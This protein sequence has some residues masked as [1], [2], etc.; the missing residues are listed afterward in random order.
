MEALDCR[1]RTPAETGR[2]IIERYNASMIGARLEARIDA[3][4][5]GLKV[6]LLEA[7][8]RHSVSRLADGSWRL[9]IE[10]GLCPA[11]G[12]ISGVH[13]VVSADDGTV[14]TCERGARAARIDG[15]EKRVV[16]SGAV[17]R[18]ASHLAIDA[19][20]RLLFIAD[21]GNNQIVA[22][23]AADLKVEQTWPAPGMPQL[24]L[25]NRDGIVCVTGGGTGTLTIARPHGGRYV[26]QTIAVGRWPHDPLLTLDGGYLFV[27]CVGDSELVKVR[28]ADG[29]IVGRCA[30]GDG[31]SH[32]ALHPDGT[33]VYAAGS[34]DGTLTCVSVEGERVA[35][36]ESGGWAHAIDITPDGRWV[37]VA[38]F[39]DDTLA[40]F[41]PDTLA[42]VALLPTE[43]YP[44]GLDVSPDG[45][46]AI[47]TGFA[48]D[49][50]RLYDAQ[51]HTEIARI[52]VGL[53]SS[54]SVFLN[55][56]ATAFVG[57]SVS[58]HVA[59]ID[60]AARRSVKRLRLDA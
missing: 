27:P 46:Y 8:V 30:V 43:S 24:P 51:A 28:L 41:D 17:A 11:Q 13:H 50:V 48:S 20:A 5:S 60:L 38:N 36:A 26:E 52:E 39:L 23:R 22:A 18:Q 4:D 12:S 49:H 35:D 37:L 44:H 15:H 45:R 58:D 29:R 47:A 2:A 42:R 57:C 1:A 19:D 33:R 54:H 25:V 59:C 14:W 21:A 16:A 6:W 56:E 10:R 53:G 40:V 9:F 55:D 7:G 31:P 3:Y 32:L 34:W